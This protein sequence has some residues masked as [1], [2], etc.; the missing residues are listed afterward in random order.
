[1]GLHLNGSPAPFPGVS[2]E[3][4]ALLDYFQKA[5]NLKMG[6]IFKCEFWDSLVLQASETVPGVRYAIIALASVHRSRFT[7]GDD[8]NT[9]SRKHDDSFALKQYNNAIKDLI[10]HQSIHIAAISCMLFTCLEMLRG[11]LQRMNTHFQHGINLVRHIQGRPRRHQRNRGILMVRDPQPLDE[12][13]IHI[14]TRLRVQFLMLGYD[15]L[16]SGPLFA[17]D[18]RHTRPLTIPMVFSTVSAVRRSLDTILN[19]VVDLIVCVEKEYLTTN[20]HSPPPPTL[21]GQ[22]RELQVTVSDWI[23]AFEISI[24][25]LLLNAPLFERL[26]LCILRIYGDIVTV[27]LSTCF[28]VKETVYDTFTSVFES[29]IRQSEELFALG[30]NATPGTKMKGEGGHRSV[31]SKNGSCFSTDMFCYPPLYYTALK[32]RIPHL[33]RHA[34]TLLQQYP[35]IK[36]LWTGSLLARTATRII[37]MEERGFSA[38]LSPSSVHCKDSRALRITSPAKVVQENLVSSTTEGDACSS[39]SLPMPF[40]LPEFSRIHHIRCLFTEEYFTS[41]FVLKEGPIGTLICHRFRHELGRTGGWEVKTCY[42]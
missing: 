15:P 32:C 36:G 24:P 40:I 39:A 41:G 12:D 1:M 11:E 13:L 18:V 28:S 9:F 26:G 25:S 4:R 2:R 27:M 14:F 30:V 42:I 31:G 33:R 21:V 16:D 8:G 22:Q 35:Q 37:D 10:S 20:V 23:A 7:T 19:S 5:P 3:E 29:I 17:P 38:A 34:V 6:G